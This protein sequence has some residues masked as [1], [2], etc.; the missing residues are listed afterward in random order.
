ME[1]KDLVDLYTYEVLSQQLDQYGYLKPEG[2]LDLFN[3]AAVRQASE[4]DLGFEILIKENLIW[5]MLRQKVELVNNV[6]TPKVIKLKTWPL[7]S[8]KFEYFRD[9][10]L[11]DENDVLLYKG[12]SVWCLFNLNTNFM[13]LKN[14]KYFAGNFIAEAPQINIKKLSFVY[15]ESFEKVITFTILKSYLDKNRHTNN[16][17][18]IQMVYDSSKFDYFN[19]FQIEYIKQT[20]QGQKIDIFRKD[21]SAN[22]EYFVGKADNN[23]IFKACVNGVINEDK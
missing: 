3:Q 8:N 2:V 5:I 9:F 18:Y 16:A 22:C 20:F 6:Y 17:R 15:D 13:E 23:I 1:S 4:H 14:K 11:Y 21:I 10:S 19:D 12:S 7:K